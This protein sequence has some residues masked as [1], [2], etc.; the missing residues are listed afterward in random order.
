LVLA[1]RGG[2]TS[3]LWTFARAGAHEVRFRGAIPVPSGRQTI[4][5]SAPEHPEA[6]AIL[7]TLVRTHPREADNAKWVRARTADLEKL[8]ARLRAPDPRAVAQKGGPGGYR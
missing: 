3:H 6:P 5:I 1:V 4:E 7:L 2:L 8:E